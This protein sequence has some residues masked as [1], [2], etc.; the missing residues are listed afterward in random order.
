MDADD[1]AALTEGVVFSA[2]MGA[3]QIMMDTEHAAELLDFARS[4]RA[5]NDALQARTE[6]AEARAA[7]L[8]A[9]IEAV[10]QV[11][12]SSFYGP[13]ADRNE[14][15]AWKGAL[16]KCRAALADASKG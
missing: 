10:L 3:K 2:N 7:K 8:R 15:R 6:K 9:A 13:D 14:Q 12:R 16:R 11:D 1:I 4:A 5:E